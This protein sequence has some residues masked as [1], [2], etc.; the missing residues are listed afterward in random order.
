MNNTLYYQVDPT[1]FI[2][3]LLIL[4]V[5]ATVINAVITKKSLKAAKEQTEAAHKQASAT[6]ELNKSI[7]SMIWAINKLQDDFL[8]G[9]DRQKQV[10]KIIRERNIDVLIKS[11]LSKN[12]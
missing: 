3:I 7:D 2:V 5:I 12:S 6:I 4:L 11:Q 10:E 9:E 8:S 1:W